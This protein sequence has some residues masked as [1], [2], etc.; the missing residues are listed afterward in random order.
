MPMFKKGKTESTGAGEATAA[1]PAPA[2][3]QAPAASPTPP[4]RDTV[5]SVALAPVDTAAEEALAA[6]GAAEAAAADDTSVSK[7]MHIFTED[8]EGLNASATI[9]EP[10]LEALTMEQVA[11]NATALLDE[12]RSIG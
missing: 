4:P 1:A 2:V 10:F 6:E 7:M 11:A 5:P 8:Q 3:T 9:Y 12:L